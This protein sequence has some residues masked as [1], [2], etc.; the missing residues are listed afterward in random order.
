L[1]DIRPKLQQLLESRFGKGFVRIEDSGIRSGSIE[2]FFAVMSIGGAVYTFFK[3]YEAL[4][5][6]FLLFM[7][8]VR[9]LRQDILTISHRVV[10]KAKTERRLRRGQ[11]HQGTV[12]H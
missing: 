12:S 11:R 6:G 10:K 4:R 9:G 5:K 2:M 3:D 7:E 8:D 1:D